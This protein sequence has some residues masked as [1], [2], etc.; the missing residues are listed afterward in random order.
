MRGFEKPNVLIEER[1]AFGAS[2]LEWQVG[3]SRYAEKAML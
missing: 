3:R 1:A 2:L